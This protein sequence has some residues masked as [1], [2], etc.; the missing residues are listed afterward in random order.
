MR[1]LI[2]FIVKY[3]KTKN[4]G[5]AMNFEPIQNKKNYQ[6]IIEQFVRLIT[7]GKVKPG[8]KLPPERIMAENLR[9]SRS[10]LREAL[11][12][13]EALGL[14][15]IKSGEG[16]F[17]TNVNFMPFVNLI[18]PIILGNQILEEEIFVMRKLFGTFCAKA[19]AKN[20]AKMP[21]KMLKLKGILKSMQT[22]KDIDARTKLDAS[23]HKTVCDMAENSLISAFRE[24]IE[25]LLYQSIRLSQ[26]EGSKD[27]RVFKCLHDQHCMIYQALYERDEKKAGEAMDKHLLY[28]K[29]LREKRN[30]PVVLNKERYSNAE[31]LT[32][33][34]VIY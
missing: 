34:D 5:W 28:T 12:V 10:S 30:K 16:S 15:E 20:S 4:T 18:V 33:K 7:E 27:L 2:N 32:E 29:D 11:S 24:C 25:S 17:I 8:D 13:M 9:V 31:E 6:N 19:A 21:E 22:E 23:F 14:V 3:T 1:Y 26:E